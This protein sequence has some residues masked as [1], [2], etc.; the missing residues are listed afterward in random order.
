MPTVLTPPKS[1]A[2]LAAAAEEAVAE[3]VVRPTAAAPAL[4]QRL[5]GSGERL[6]DTVGYVQALLGISPP[7]STP[8][9]QQQ[10]HLLL[11]Y[12]QQH[13]PVEQHQQQHQQHQQHQQ[14]Q[15]Q[16]SAPVQQQ[17]PSVGTLP[18]T[19]PMRTGQ[20]RSPLPAAQISV[21]LSPRSAA[22]AAAGTSNT[23]PRV[24]VC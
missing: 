21:V 5:S 2:D 22:A 8:P 12:Q 3:G 13:A 19:P 24:I 9:Q 1:Y 18:P 17:Q 14:Q 11:P 20:D 15:Q 10:Q 4:N 6:G 23:A 16:Q 7:P